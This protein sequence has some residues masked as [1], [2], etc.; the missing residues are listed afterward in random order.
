MDEIKLDLV[1]TARAV[2]ECIDTPPGCCVPEDGA[3]LRD[4]ADE[5]ER[6]KVVAIRCGALYQPPCPIC[7]HNGPDY[8][9]PD[10][11][12]CVALITRV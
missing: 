4:L 1:G 3:L 9:E 10:V 11:H 6:L 5:I 8:W 7:G 12:A 2:A